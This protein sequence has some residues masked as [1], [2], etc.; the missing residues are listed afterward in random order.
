MLYA[1]GSLERTKLPD[2]NFFDR[3]YFAYYE[4]VDLAWRMRLS[5]FKSYYCPSAK[6]F[7]V[8]S[9]TA[10]KASLMKAYY[11]HRNYFFTILKNYPCCQLVKTLFWRFLSYLQLV[12]N[13]YRKKKRETEFVKDYSKS[14]VALAIL[15]AWGSVVLNF[16][17]LLK[18]R[19]YI[20]KHKVSTIREIQEWVVKYKAE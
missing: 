1:R 17:N 14:Q 12:L 19:I 11:L 16:P 5:D 8:H 3:D 4:D 13:V 20:Q 10:G 18:K 7:H 9:G 6:V 15:R 2:G